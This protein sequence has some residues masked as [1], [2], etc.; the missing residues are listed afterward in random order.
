MAVRE[1]LGIYAMPFSPQDGNT[2]VI[3]T[4]IHDSFA[5]KWRGKK[6]RGEY[7]CLPR[8]GQGITWVPKTPSLC[9]PGEVK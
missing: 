9:L 3:T 8:S 6:Q 2:V 7:N 5:C 1:Q 4:I